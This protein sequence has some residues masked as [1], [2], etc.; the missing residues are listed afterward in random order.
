[1]GFKANYLTNNTLKT[2]QLKIG[3]C[4]IIIVNL[5]RTNNKVFYGKYLGYSIYRHYYADLINYY[6]DAEINFNLLDVNYKV[7]WWVFYII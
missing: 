5:T 1:M 4:Y 6:F 2:S 3:V 7:D